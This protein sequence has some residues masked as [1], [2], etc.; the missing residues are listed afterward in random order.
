[1]WLM[2]STVHPKVYGLDQNELERYDLLSSTVNDRSDSTRLLSY[3]RSA[4]CDGADHYDGA[5]H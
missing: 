2:I 3:V 5:L 4:P 1:M